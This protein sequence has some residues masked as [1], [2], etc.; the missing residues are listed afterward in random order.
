MAFQLNAWDV[1][2]SAWLG[3]YKHA[4]ARHEL[5]LS[6]DHSFSV[7]KSSRI[8]IWTDQAQ[9][10]HSPQCPYGARWMTMDS[11]EL[12]SNIIKHLIPTPNHLK[13]KNDDVEDAHKYP[14]AHQNS[15]ELDERGKYHILVEELGERHEAGVNI[16]EID[17]EDLR[18]MWAR[19]EGS[20]D[21]RNDEKY[22]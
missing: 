1:E 5:N 9:A 2:V 8:S 4:W 11:I 18:E 7:P 19:E 20:I 6:S 3:E 12:V 13:S 15:K 16:G 21:E 22:V 10:F 14:T 17:R